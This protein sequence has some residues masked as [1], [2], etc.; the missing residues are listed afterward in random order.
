MTHTATE[1]VSGAVTA[2]LVLPW[3]LFLQAALAV[4]RLVI[5]R[6]NK[7]LPAPVP[8]DFIHGWV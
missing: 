4:F 7:A 3:L 6:F 8:I 2:E 5:E 1:L